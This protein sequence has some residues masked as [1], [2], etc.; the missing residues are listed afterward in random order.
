MGM[1]C[2]CVCMC[3]IACLQLLCADVCMWMWRLDVDIQCLLYYHCPFYLFETRSLSEPR[4]HWLARLAS[5][6][7][8]GFPL[9]APPIPVAAGLT[10]VCYHSRLLLGCWDQTQFLMLVWQA[11]YLL[12]C[13]ISPMDY[14]LLWAYVDVKMLTLLRI[15]HF[16]FHKM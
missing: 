7:V 8:L 13:P 3:V 2:V 10:H 11:L 16:L 9:S 5:Q 12:S 4:A 6:Q 14:V 1:V 15:Q